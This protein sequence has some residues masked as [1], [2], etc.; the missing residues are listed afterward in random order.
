MYKKMYMLAI[1]GM[2]TLTPYYSQNRYIIRIDSKGGA[3]PSII[4]PNFNCE[5]TTFLPYHVVKKVLN[6]TNFTLVISD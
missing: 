4:L 3:S 2:L 5:S 6:V 1:V